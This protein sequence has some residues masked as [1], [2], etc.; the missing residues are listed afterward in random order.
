MRHTYINKMT[1]TAAATACTAILTL[2]SCS[3]FTDVQQK[4]KNLLASTNELEMLLNQEIELGSAND[5]RTLTGDLLRS[6]SNVPSQISQ[7]NK[8][9]PVILWTWDEANQGK[10][11]ELT[12]SDT[13]Y[14]EFYGY[15]GTIA[16]PIL[17]KVDATNGEENVKQQL[18][19][20]ALTLRAWS[21]YLLINKFAKGYNP[22][23]AA[24]DPGI[25]NMTEDVNITVPQEQSTVQQIYDQIIADCDAAIEADALPK[26]AVNRMRWSKVGPYAVKAMAL[27]NEQKW[28]EAEETAKKALAISPDLC[29]YWD[30]SMQTTTTGYIL[31][32]T[33]PCILRP[34]LKAV[35]DYFFSNNLEF[36][37][38]IP[39]ES[40]DAFEAGHAFKELMATDRMMSDYTGGSALDMMGL[41]YTM[42]Y[43][44]TSGWNPYGPTSAQM[45]LAI[46][47]CAIHQGRIDEA[48]DYLD[49]L[50]VT[51]INPEVYKPLQGSI[52]TKADAIG[53]LKQ[54]NHDENIYT[55]YHF[56][57]LKRWNQVQGWQETLTKTISDVTYTLKPDSKL[58]IFPFPQNAINNNPNLK[59][60]YAQ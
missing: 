1:M 22:Q 18:K 28:A 12:A 32:D 50:R 19:C 57:S 35:E 8:T 56:I 26:A 24:T 14:G 58:W 42:T 51:R 44:M 37:N 41:D 38:P 53:H 10:M 16:N 6:F 20:E 7:P 23:T 31:G 36:Y 25:I 34:R 40:W 13:E 39:T 27:L 29:N 3:D 5:F 49:R 45:Y 43:D 59:Q 60:N 11:A 30:P 48:M 33:Y 52:T 46:A 4:G 2:G 54:V 15:I 47:E 9:R 21:N 17:S 55:C